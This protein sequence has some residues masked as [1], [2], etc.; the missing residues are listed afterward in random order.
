MK[1][2]IGICFALYYV[3]HLFEPCSHFVLRRGPDFRVDNRG[4]TIYGSI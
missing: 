1:A 4:L 3:S 2:G